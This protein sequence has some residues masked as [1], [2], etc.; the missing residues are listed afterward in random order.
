MQFDRFAFIVALTAALVA[1]ARSQPT[2]GATPAETSFRGG[3]GGIAPPSSVP[4]GAVD[5]KTAPDASTPAPVAT[6]DCDALVARSREHPVFGTRIVLDA[7]RAEEATQE[8]LARYGI[9]SDRSL[10]LA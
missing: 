5:P 4:Q 8:I 3:I 6:S 9:S 1:C 2:T 7:A 10:D